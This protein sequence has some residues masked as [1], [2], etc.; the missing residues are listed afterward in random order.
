MTDTIGYLTSII[1]GIQLYPVHETVIIT[2]L[3]SYEPIQ[4]FVGGPVHSR[5]SLFRVPKPSL[6]MELH[7]SAKTSI[8]RNSSHF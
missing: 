1:S 6:V 4:G 8:R 2:E 5:P 3:C 7:Q